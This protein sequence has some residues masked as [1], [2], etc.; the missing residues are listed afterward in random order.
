MEQTEPIWA[1]FHVR[2]V[3]WG[4]R[5]AEHI[6]HAQT[7]VFDVFEG[8]RKVGEAPNTKTCPGG[9]VFVFKGRGGT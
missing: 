5:G 6:E 1:C 2:Q 4:G 3:G 7:G 9:R 8:V